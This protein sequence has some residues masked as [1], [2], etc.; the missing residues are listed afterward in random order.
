MY[1]ACL[2]RSNPIGTSLS[3]ALK[4]TMQQKHNHV[5]TPKEV[6]KRKELATKRY[7]DDNW[8]SLSLYKQQ[9]YSIF[10]F[11]KRSM[12]SKW[13]QLNYAVTS[14]DCESLSILWSMWSTIPYLY[15]CPAAQFW[16]IFDCERHINCIVYG[17][18]DVHAICHGYVHVSSYE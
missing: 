8:S 12:I 10:F 15:F 9:Y 11:C 13:I 2:V 16:N 5:D 18:G 1:M 7:Q 17:T 4:K 6:D 14:N 3:G